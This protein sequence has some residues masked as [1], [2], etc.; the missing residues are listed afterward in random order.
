MASTKNI[1]LFS[2]LIFGVAVNGYVY[3]SGPSPRKPCNPPK[4][5]RRFQINNDCVN[6]AFR[7]L[8]DD[9]GGARQKPMG[10]QNVDKETAKKWLETAFDLAFEFND[11]FATTPGEKDATEEILRQ[12]REWV[13][14]N[15]YNQGKEDEAKATK[16]HVD[17]KSSSDSKNLQVVDEVVSERPD[18]EDKSNDDTFRVSIDLPGVDREDVDITVDGAF[19]LIRG[20]R[21]PESDGLKPRRVYKKKVSLPENEVDMDKL[22]A[23]LK[24]GVLII[25]APK[26]KPINT[27]RKIPVC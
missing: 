19:L 20:K 11:D 1:L 17:E 5:A 10:G 23:N 2:P 8:Q 12:S 4:K 13:N 14:L 24:N 6:E 3:S 22:E 27:K 15:L 7:D 25:S 18:S 9:L 26:K 21:D 16:N